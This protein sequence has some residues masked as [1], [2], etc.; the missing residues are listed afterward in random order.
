MQNYPAFFSDVDSGWAVGD[1]HLFHPRPL[2]LT[3]AL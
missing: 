1:V 2:K 3:R